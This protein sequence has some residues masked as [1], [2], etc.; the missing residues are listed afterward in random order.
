MSTRPV[1][2]HEGMFL[3]PHHFQSAQRHLTAIAGRGDKWDLHYNWGLRAIEIDQDALTN[4]RLV[5]RSLQARM[6]DG[7]LVSIPE[8]AAALERNDLREAMGRESAVTVLLGVPML[9]EGRANVGTGARDEPARF[10]FDSLQ[11][12]DENTG[13]NPQPVEFRRL[14]LRLLFANE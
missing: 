3:R 2:W 11:L 14:N 5:V 6:R 7:T 12:E 1:H 8:D 10:S 13:T 4:H 9:Q